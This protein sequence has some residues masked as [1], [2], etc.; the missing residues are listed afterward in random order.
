VTINLSKEENWRSKE[1]ST[2][3]QEKAQTKRKKR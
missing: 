2:E 3:E 1:E